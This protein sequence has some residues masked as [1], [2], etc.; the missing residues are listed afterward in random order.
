MIDIEFYIGAWPHAC[1]TQSSCPNAGHELVFSG[2]PNTV[3]EVES[4]RWYLT[5]GRDASVRVYL[6]EKK[7]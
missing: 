1:R 4:V 5:P 2:S 7:T 3:Y 6:K